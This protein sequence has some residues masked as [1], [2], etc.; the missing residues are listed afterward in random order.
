MFE[1]EPR[2]EEDGDGDLIFETL[3]GRVIEA[4]HDDKTHAALLDYA[5][6][7]KLL[8]GAARHYRALKDDPEKGALAK[9]KLD[10]IV[11]A[12]TEM[13]L[14]MRTPPPPKT[15]AWLTIVT[16][17]VCLGLLSLLSYAMLFRHRG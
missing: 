11:L 15:P 9:K 8:P 7:K 17:I 6:R 12:A 14:S 3:W 1:S 10:G 4:W 5:L 13:M 16:V 2:D